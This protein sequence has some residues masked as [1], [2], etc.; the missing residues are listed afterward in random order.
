M[1]RHPIV[2]NIDKDNQIN[3]RH[4]VR[5]SPLNIAPTRRCLKFTLLKM[6]GILSFWSYKSL[7]VSPCSCT[8]DLS[9]SMRTRNTQLP[10]LHSKN[11]LI[12]CKI[13]STPSVIAPKS[14]IVRRFSA[15][16][17]WPLLFCGYVPPHHSLARYALENC[18]STSH[19]FINSWKFLPLNMLPESQ[20]TTLGGPNLQNTCPILSDA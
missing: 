17:H 18:C 9:T 5:T 7:S 11:D 16:F 19:R 1:S 14:I 13:F 2:I 8:L 20:R 10:T 12:G 4:S 6:K 15:P 3:T